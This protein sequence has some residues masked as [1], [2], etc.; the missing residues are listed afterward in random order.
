MHE[1]ALMESLVDAVRENV[2]GARVKTVRLEVGKLSCVLPDALR[3]CFEISTQ[4]TELEGATPERRPDGR[5]KIAVEIDATARGR[6]PWSGEVHLCLL[7][8]RLGAEAPERVTAGEAAVEMRQSLQG[9]FERF[10]G[11]LDDCIAS[12]AGDEACWRLPVSAEPAELAR[13][14][15]NM[16]HGSS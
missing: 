11:S 16:F 6:I 5:L 10:A 12:L 9:G 3:F 4:G 13:T 15:Y 8:R 7:T 14:L 2:R 1:L